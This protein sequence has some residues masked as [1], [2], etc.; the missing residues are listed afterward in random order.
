MFD[1]FNFVHCLIIPTE[2]ALTD[3]T[4][5]SNRTITFL[6]DSYSSHYLLYYIYSTDL[7]L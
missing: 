1:K 5:Y 6:I 3:L 4:K 7:H 2:L